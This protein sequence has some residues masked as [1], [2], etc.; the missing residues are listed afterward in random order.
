MTIK[1]GG[2]A[3]PINRNS[4]TFKI[5][6]YCPN[7]G[8]RKLRGS[9]QILK[10]RVFLPHEIPDPGRWM[11][12]YYCGSIYPIYNVKKESKLTSDL[13]IQDNPFGKIQRD[14]ES[15]IPRPKHRRGFNERLDRNE[16]EIKDPEL[17]R[18]L[19]KGAKLLLSYTES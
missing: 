14:E 7:C 16:P 6:S 19:K 3:E 12:C 15:D 2:I 18:E 5:P 1:R 9:E 4:K 11:Q 13:Q 8:E 17:K 10:P